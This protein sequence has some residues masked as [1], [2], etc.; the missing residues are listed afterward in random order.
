MF[1]D[2]NLTL[3]ASF[4]VK[5]LT[6]TETGLDNSPPLDLYTQLKAT[7][8]VLEKLKKQVGPFLIDSA[9]RTSE[10]NK[11]VGGEST[12]R[13][14]YG[15]A[16]DIVPTSMSSKDYFAKIMS[17][18]AL[19]NILG[20]ISLK[21]NTIHATLPYTNS[22]GRVVAG[23]A[24]E[25]VDGSYFSMTAEKIA[26]LTG[27]GVK[28]VQEAGTKVAASLEEFADDPKK[29]F[30]SAFNFYDEFGLINPKPFILGSVVGIALLGI[31]LATKDEK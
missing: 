11:K 15:E 27:K 23:S 4:K 6:V 24:R 3:S 5:D 30:S 26:E 14:L 19:K 7:A 13:H 10:V 31:Y 22:S 21:T 18:D 20:E 16:F 28:A 29:W 1:L 2:P 9:F 12:S 8:E 25:L 17:N